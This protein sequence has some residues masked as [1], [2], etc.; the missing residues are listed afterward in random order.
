VSDFEPEV[1]GEELPAEVAELRVQVA[2]EHADLDEA[3]QQLIDAHIAVYAEEI[4]RVIA[5]HKAVADETDLE[6][7]AATRWSAIWELSGR[8][9]AISRVV[10]HDLRGGFASEA[11]GSLRALFEAMYLVAAIV[12][13]PGEEGQAAEACEEDAQGRE[14]A[15]EDVLPKWLAGEWVRPKTARE[16]VARKEKLAK[17]RMREARVPFEGRGVAT[18]GAEL[19]DLLS[20]P[21]HHRREGFRETVSVEL[22]EFTYGPHPNAEVRARHVEF[23]G[24]LLETA[25]LVVIDGLADIIGRD[26]AREAAPAMQARL[27]QVRRDAPLPE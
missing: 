26:Y 18:V 24:H 9:L 16:A 15:N 23:A 5:A 12:F 4:E 10:I 1:Q 7:R 11:I 17:E 6:I 27:E 2:A 3:L 20:Q 19:Y 14:T 13:G 25:L 22:R 8:C 21:A